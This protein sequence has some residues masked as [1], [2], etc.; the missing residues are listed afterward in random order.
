M[1]RIIYFGP[2]GTGKT[3]TL[4]DRMEEHL[5]AGVPPERIAFL[6]FTRRARAEAVQR[7]RDVLGIDATSLPHFRTIHSMAF[8]GLGLKDGDVVTTKALKEFGVAMGLTFGAQG[9][10]ELAAEGLQGN[11][12]GD[13]LLALDNIARVRGETL[14]A[15]WEKAG[16]NIDWI[17]VEHFSR[18]YALYKH[19]RAMLDFTDVL[20]E[21]AR[22]GG[23]I[24]VDVAFIDEAQDL[25]AL[26]WY[27]ALQAVEYADQQY[28][29]GD[30]DQAIYR[31][32]GASVEELLRLDGKQVVLAQ[33]YRLPAKVHALAARIVARIRHRVPKEF[34]A[35]DDAG[36]I[37]SH[38]SMESLPL[39]YGERWLW[40][41]RNRYLLTSLRN[42]LIDKG[43]VY[44]EHGNSSVVDSD[45]EAIYTWER[46]RT[47]RDVSVAAARDLYKKLSTRTQVAHGH[48]LIPGVAEDA[49]VVA[50][51]LRANHGLLVDTA[52]PWFD[53][54]TSI[55]LERRAYY[56]RLLRE[57]RSLR[58]AP[59]VQLETIH[60]AKGAECE[61]VAVW[62]EC[63]RRVH[64]E[65]NQTQEGA[66]DEHRVQYV[67]MTRA[68]E[69]LH[70]VAAPSRYAYD[71]PRN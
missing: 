21:F 64:A 5:R 62:L 18:S 68:R 14:R 19:E 27:A 3:T 58:I 28:I 2:P 30:D 39:K 43:Y 45:R 57:R 56:R 34:R 7:V 70:I 24:P 69:Q 51:D 67:A 8:R 54:L 46:I 23:R 59:E 33:S 52:T 60:G 16:V 41:V 31:W 10:T 6:T 25:S 37:K 9:A 38:A 26:Q 11:N 42:H 17:K 63:S 1:Q 49:R 71:V 32:A 50:A 61:R 20:L 36:I 4:L 22:S 40:L 29:A 66:D 47:G 13:V 35:R 44:M 65:A 12:E 53:V 48:K 15:T 55:S